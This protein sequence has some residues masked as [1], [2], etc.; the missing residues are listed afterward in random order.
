M[1]NCEKLVQLESEL[2]S[3]NYDIR[4]MNK[5]QIFQ[6]IILKYKLLDFGRV[7]L[8]KNDAECHLEDGGV[9]T[10]KQWE[11]ILENLEAINEYYYLECFFRSCLI[12][13]HD[14]NK[15]ILSSLEVLSLENN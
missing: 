6:Y 9:Y 11:Y 10:D 1:K 3:L 7:F 15:N 8:D 5:Y 4:E 2:K 14:K 13:F 12:N